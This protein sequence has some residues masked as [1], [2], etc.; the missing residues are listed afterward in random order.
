MEDW[1]PTFLGTIALVYPPRVRVRATVKLSATFF[2]DESSIL[3]PLGIFHVF[4]LP[5]GQFQKNKAHPW[6]F[7]EILLDP[8]EMPR[9]QKPKPLKV[10]HYF[11][12]VTLGNCTSFLI[13]PQKLHVLFLWSQL[14]WLE[15]ALFSKK[16]L[17]NIE[18]HS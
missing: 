7:H 6:K 14:L 15:M 8:L 3:N 9:L 12:L 2:H 11:F 10:P 4:I 16:A 13:N 5:L 18:K 17:H 1:E